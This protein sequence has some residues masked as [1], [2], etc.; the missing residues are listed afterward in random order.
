MLILL[1]QMLRQSD[2]LA[3]AVCEICPANEVDIL[4]PIL[5][6]VFDTRESLL[7]LMKSAIDREIAR[8]GSSSRWLDLLLIDTFAQRA[9]ANCSVAT[10]SALD[11]WAP[12]RRCRA[13][14]IYA[15]SS[16]PSSPR[17]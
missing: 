14:I 16:S 8:T 9:I 5:L 15:G 12:A 3:L 1:R 13:T 10:P 4:I 17:L 11:Y 2:L 6:N 7:R